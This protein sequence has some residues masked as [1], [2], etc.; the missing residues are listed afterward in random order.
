MQC[1][2][3]Y[4]SN[5]RILTSAGINRDPVT[6]NEAHLVFDLVMN[7]LKKRERK[8]NIRVQGLSQFD[9]ET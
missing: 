5:D 8:P 9:F 2:T 3:K 7:T 4:F 1:S 6:E